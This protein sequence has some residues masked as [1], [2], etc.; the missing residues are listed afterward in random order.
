MPDFRSG[1]FASLQ[2]RLALGFVLALGVA[3]A[4]IGIA[5]GVVTGKQTERF[6][7]DRDSAQVARVQ[8][9]VSNYY[10]R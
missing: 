3:L 9:F 5:A 4:L 8:R 6:E 2:F 1:L 7:R 10:A